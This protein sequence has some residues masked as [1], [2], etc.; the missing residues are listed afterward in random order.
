MI[1]SS[2]ILLSRNKRLLLD[3]YIHSELQ[4][5]DFENQFSAF[6]SPIDYSQESQSDDVQRNREAAPESDRMED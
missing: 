3:R 1:T 6:D 4:E 2:R 5:N